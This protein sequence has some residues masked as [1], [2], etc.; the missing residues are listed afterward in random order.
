M[1]AFLLSAGFGQ[2]LG[3][4]GEEVPKALLPL[5]GLPQIQF[6]LYKLRNCG[7]SEVGINLH[8]QAELVMNTLGDHFQGLKLHYFYEEKIL[9]TAGGLKNAEEFLSEK[10]E[11]F[12][13]INS[14]APCSIDLKMAL[15]H[16]KNGNYLSTLI[17]RRSLEAVS[18]GILGVDT[19]GRLIKFLSFLSPGRT[20]DSIVGGMFTGLSIMSP[21]IF[22]HIPSRGFCDIAQ[23]IYPKLILKNERIGGVISKSYWADTGT[24]ERYIQA[25]R[26]LLSGEFVPDFDWPNNEFLL[27]EGEKI[28][29][30]EGCIEPPVL[31]SKDATIEKDAVAS[32]NS[33]LMSGCCLS[34]GSKTIGSILFPDSFVGNDLILTDCV[35]G[36]KTIVS[37]NRRRSRNM[38]FINENKYKI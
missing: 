11:P 8:H 6:S 26:D 31:I 32:Q 3:E 30:G 17:L 23:E 1:R 38:V 28:S 10:K 27:I 22:K 33:I 29:W 25:N 34:K 5:G 36:L 14:D 7:V 15:D 18:Y 19:E 20:D 13:V 35:V 12:F 9:G 2:R 24:V 16:H 4:L 37:L 21:E